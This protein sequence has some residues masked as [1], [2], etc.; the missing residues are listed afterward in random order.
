M[1]ILCVL[2]ELASSLYNPFELGLAVIKGTMDI[3]FYYLHRSV[4]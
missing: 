3:Q 1:A 2:I 4:G